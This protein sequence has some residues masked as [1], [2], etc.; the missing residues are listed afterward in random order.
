ME[1]NN[2][3]KLIS[4]WTEQSAAEPLPA[5]LGFA[6]FSFKVKLRNL[7]EWIACA[8][9]IIWFGYNSLVAPSLWSSL[10]YAELSVAAV[11]IGINLYRKGRILGDFSEEVALP[12]IEYLNRYQ[13][14][15]KRQI[16]LLSGVR[17]WYVA[18]LA[19]GMIGL[20]LEHIFNKWSLVN[21]P[22]YDIMFLKCVIAMCLWLIW[23]NE[24]KTVGKLKKDLKSVEDAVTGGR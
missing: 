4:Q 11:F 2:D 15:L 12:T 23:L 10:M 22:W 1:H 16:K 19:F 20:K 18:P 7:M 17:Y 21:P 8:V 13:E 14:N 24:V 3:E 5:T 9:I 6:K